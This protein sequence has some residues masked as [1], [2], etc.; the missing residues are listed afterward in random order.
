MQIIALLSDEQDPT[1]I[2]NSGKDALIRAVLT[3]LHV[4]DDRLTVAKKP[5]DVEKPCNEITSTELSAEE[6]LVLEET[7]MKFS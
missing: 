1:A 4:K 5:P 7:L 6:L 3:Q 2:L